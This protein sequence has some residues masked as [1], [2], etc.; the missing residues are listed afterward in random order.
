[1]PKEL[2]ADLQ[3]WMID[4]LGV[5]APIDLE[6]GDVRTPDD[7]LV[8][9][10]QRV[11]AAYVRYT[12]YMEE[13]RANPGEDLCSAMLTLTDAAG[14]PMLSTDEVMAHMVGIT[15]AGTDTT[16]NLIVNMVRLFTENPDQLKLVLDTPDLWDNAVQE[17]L[18]RA[19]VAVQIGRISTRESEIGGVRIPARAALALSLPAANGDPRKFVSPLHFDVQ[20]PNAGEHLGLGRGRHY[21][22]GATLAA[23]EARIALETLYRR[24]PDLRADLDQ[25][26][27]FVPSL[28]I[29]GIVSQR[30]TWSAI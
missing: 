12:D 28:A 2:L 9:I 18:R 25:E 23:P 22:L 5:L 3:A 27:Q 19:P 10:F 17:G 1:V 6:P 21:C 26:L 15:A 4:V 30:T 29:R 8:G 16:A 11:H 13:K 20:R 7:D 14:E 24:L